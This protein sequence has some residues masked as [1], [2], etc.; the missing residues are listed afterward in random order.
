MGEMADL[1]LEQ[2]GDPDEF[3]LDGFEKI[4]IDPDCPDV[5]WPVAKPTIMCRCCGTLGLVW[6]K[7]PRG[8]WRLYAGDALHQC[9]VNP[10]KD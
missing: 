5:A 4:W 10:L 6:G 8:P 1:A 2:M 7:Q 9:P 3:G